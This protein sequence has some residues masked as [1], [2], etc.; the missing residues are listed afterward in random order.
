MKY[1]IN[2][3]KFYVN[4][5]THN[6]D[7]LMWAMKWIILSSFVL[8]SKIYNFAVRQPTIELVVMDWDTAEA[9]RDKDYTLATSWDTITAVS[10]DC[11]DQVLDSYF[12]D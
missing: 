2:S 1:L 10:S 8:P 5:T 7:N 3:P 12:L 9:T 6:E 4:D 11:N